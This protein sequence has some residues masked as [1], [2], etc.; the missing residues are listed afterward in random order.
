MDRLR[1]FFSFSPILLFFLWHRFYRRYPSANPASEPVM[2]DLQ[3]LTASATELQ[4]LLRSGHLTSFQ[5]VKVCLN[6][7][8]KH[9]RS[10]PTLY[11]IVSTPPEKYILSVADGLGKE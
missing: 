10:S 6:Q 2:K 4:G 3:L 5:L 1:L 9:D 11:A 8:A 7:I